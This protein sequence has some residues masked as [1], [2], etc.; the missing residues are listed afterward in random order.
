MKI[1]RRHATIG[2]LSLLAGTSM[3][4]MARA[5][6]GEGLRDVGEGLDDFVLAQDAYIYGY[7]LVTMEMTR[8]V[9]TNAASVQGHPRTDGPDH[10]A[11]PIS[12]CFVPGRDR[13]Q[14]RYSLHDRIF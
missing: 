9:V 8:R 12:G 4:T 3:S 14:R 10:Q 5:E 2:G 7:P 6:F 1:S 11:A 13:S